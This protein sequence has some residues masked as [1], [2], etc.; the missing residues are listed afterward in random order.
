MFDVHPGITGWVQIYG[1]K[2]VEWH[3]RI[4]MNNWYVDHCSF[5]L[6]AANLI[7]TI[8]KFSRML[9]MRTKGRQ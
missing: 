9:T 4:E 1:R 2:D 6:D 8:L 7:K 3:K 5:H